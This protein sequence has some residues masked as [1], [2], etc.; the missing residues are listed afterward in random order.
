VGWSV[1]IGFPL[2]SVM[3]CLPLVGGLLILA[4]G[5]GRPLVC[6]VT[7][8][9]TTLATFVLSVV[10]LFGFE[11]ELP[12][13]QY[14]EDTVLVEGL[15]V[16]YGLGVDGIAV[17]LLLLTTL[18]SVVVVIAG[19]NRTEERGRG[20]F[21][22]LLLLE[23][24]VT[25][26]FCSTD[27]IL[28][29]VFWE[30]ALV[31]MY[32][33]I[34]TWGGSRKTYA[35]VKLLLFG[36]IGSLLMLAAIIAVAL[37]ARGTG[38]GLTF[39]VQELSRIV[40]PYDLQ[41][42]AFLAFFLAFAIRVPVFPLHTWLP[43]AQAEAPTAG[44]V[45]LAGVLLK[46]GGYGMV[47]LCLP[48]FPDVSQDAVPYMVALSVIAIV[49]GAL[50]SLAQ[51]DLERLVAYSSVSQMGFVTA[52]IFAAIAIA[53]SP[54]GMEGA[55]LIMF[56]HGILA[57]ALLLLVGFLCERTHTRE[58]ADM[59]GLARP[60]PILAAFFMVFML[61]S[62]GLPGLNGFVG[63]SLSL[64]GVFHYSHVWG[65]VA[66]V[67]G[68]LTACYLLWMYQR[69][70]FN[71]R[72]DLDVT[73][74]QG[75]FDLGWREIASLFPLLVFAV[76]VGVYPE[77]FLDLLHQP[78]REILAQTGQAAGEAHRSLPGVTDLLA[79]LKGLF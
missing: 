45:I 39:N 67:G 58:I 59:S 38:T 73:P 25:G 4:V 31:P 37:Y 42:W 13:M 50:V 44:S 23:T 40:F 33:V 72:G 55:I 26:V 69:V 65:V 29:S 51:K 77:P 52:G 68:V 21:V 32:F 78:V 19:W 27:L 15:N 43:D 30:V 11:S 79:L 3:I 48:M 6:R 62:L 75:L 66:A 61:G 46:M 20:F 41:M 53:G 10:M 49:Y 54:Q 47:R 70:L 7:A 8:L 28:V 35:A 56:N 24:G 63:E 57:G 14:V 18:L 60:M 2:L 64:L 76:W 34:G 12:G 9:A 36:V 1:Q 74:K 5:K 71:D 17:L 22:W 16:R